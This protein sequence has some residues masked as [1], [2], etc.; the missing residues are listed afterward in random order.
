MARLGG[1]VAPY[2]ASA[3][4]EYIGKTAPI[5]VFGVT[6]FAAGV[7]SLFLPETMHRKLPDTIEEGERVK[8]SLRDGVGKK[9]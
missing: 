6:A 2:I 5:L 4:K 7:F 9:N 1:L 8:I 3:A